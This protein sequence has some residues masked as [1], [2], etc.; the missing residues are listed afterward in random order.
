MCKMR[1]ELIRVYMLQIAEF[2]C[3]AA[4]RIVISMLLIC[5]VSL[6][7]KLSIFEAIQ[8]KTNLF[9]LFIRSSRYQ[10]MSSG[11]RMVRSIM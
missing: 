8:V 3:L 2:W 4:I 5:P 7:V 11:S 6:T 9:V 1:G 10:R